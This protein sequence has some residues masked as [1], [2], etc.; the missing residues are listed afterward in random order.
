MEK[1]DAL[2]AKTWPEWEWGGV[3]PPATPDWLS[4]A[5][6]KLDRVSAPP[7]RLEAAAAHSPGTSIDPHSGRRGYDVHKRNREFCHALP[8]ARQPPRDVL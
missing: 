2:A 4:A 1:L 5:Q 7:E 3:P 8:A 6:K